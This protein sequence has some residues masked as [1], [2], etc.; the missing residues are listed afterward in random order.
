MKTIAARIREMLLSSM[1]NESEL[2]Y[3]KSKEN[4]PTH[5]LKKLNVLWSDIQ[6]NVPHYREQVQDG[7]IPSKISSGD[8]FM[9]FPI[10]TRASIQDN[11]AQYIDGSQRISNWSTTGG[12]TGTPFR[13]PHCPS[14]E[15][16]LT[17]NAWIGRGFYGI[18]VSDRMFHL[19]GHS[20]L[21]GKGWKRYV[22]QA[23][24]KFKNWLLGYRVFSAYH[25]TPERLREAG[26]AIIKMR[27]DYIIGYSRSLTLLAKVNADLAERF[28]DLSIKTI[29]GTTEAF[30]DPNDVSLIEK[31]FGCPV[32]ME[33]GAAETGII[34]Y[35]HPSDNRYQVFWDTYLL[36][37]I[38]TDDNC[39]KLLLTS[40]Y[41]RAMPLIRYDIGDSVQGY[42]TVGNSVISFDAV[43][44]RDN[45][46][47]EIGPGAFV[48]PV[49][50]IQC[51]QSFPGVLGVQVVQE[52]DNSISMRLMCKTP[53]AKKDEA[54]IRRNLFTLD[55][56]LG[57][58]RIDYV[59]QLDQTM[60][61]KTKWIVRR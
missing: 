6:C 23:Q 30:S 5:Q 8:D 9:Q 1:L 35:T 28:S 53:L 10:L 29:I 41:P 44:G 52:K 45:D 20:H 25:L 19:W 13:V 4:I 51:A 40:L 26:K 43:L 56:H 39:A 33:Y 55:M 46:L 24:R 38:P 17:P 14:E 7:A 18:Q 31:V 27:P 42:E 37:A 15:H 50:L 12:S 48:H 49:A 61:G 47:I 2:T 16:S 21:F 32:G 22:K 54:A 11:V 58:C 3:E 57:E 60:A 36:E 59:E 34:A